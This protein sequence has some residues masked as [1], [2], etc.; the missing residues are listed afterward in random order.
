MEIERRYLVDE[1][2][3]KVAIQLDIEAF[4]RMEETLKTAALPALCKRRNKAMRRWN[5]PKPRSIGNNM[6]TLNIPEPEGFSELSKAEQIR[7]LA[8]LWD[9]ISETPG[10]IPVPESHMVLAEERLA[11]YRRDPGR[12]RPAHDV[13]KRLE[14][15]PS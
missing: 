7:Y 10:E 5:S 9:R 12:A 3:R 13:L 8:G 2:N 1:G 6:E 4:E 11:E 15:K 14:E